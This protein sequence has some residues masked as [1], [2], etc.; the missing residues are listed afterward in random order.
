M[1]RGAEAL[2]VIRRIALLLLV[3]LIAAPTIA[4]CGK[5]PADLGPPAGEASDFP[6]KYPQ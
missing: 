1:R 6:R 2:P 4:A 5:K 3:A